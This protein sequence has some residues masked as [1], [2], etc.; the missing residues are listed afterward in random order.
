MTGSEVFLFSFLEQQ[1]IWFHHV[2]LK[3]E[4]RVQ[5]EDS[6]NQSARSEAVSRSLRVHDSSPDHRWKMKMGG[7]GAKEIG[8]DWGQNYTLFRPRR[9]NGV[10]GTKM[11]N[12][13]KMESIMLHL[14]AYGSD[15]TKYYSYSFISCASCNDLYHV[16]FLQRSNP[17]YISPPSLYLFRSLSIGR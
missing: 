14:E 11:N 2:S 16:S 7:I 4:R 8:Y 10:D 1:A 5:R 9:R 13:K 6:L 17:S 12:I 15:T 3:N